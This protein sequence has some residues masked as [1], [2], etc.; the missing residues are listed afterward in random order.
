MG[1]TLWQPRG[2]FL[3]LGLYSLVHLVLRLLVP[4][5]LTIDD[6]REALFAQTFEWGYQARQPP[7]YNWLVWA[8]VRLFGV[9]IAS[10]SSVKYALLALA[11]AFLYLGARRILV[12]PRLAAP[13][14]FSLL[15]MVPVNWVVHEALTHSIAVLTAA[16]ATVYALIRLEASGRPWAYAGLGAALG[17]GLLSKFSYALFASALLLGAL[18]VQPF[19]RRLASPWLLLTAGVVALLLLP[20]GL[21][22]YG[23]DFSLTR[24]YAEEVDPG[25]P[26]PYLAGI[27][28]AL[29]YILRVTFYYVT[30]LWIVFLVLFPGAWRAPAPLSGRALA[31]RRLLERFFLAELGLLVAGA[32]FA[33]VTYLKFRWMMPAFFLVPLYVFSRLD[34]RAVETGRVRRFAQLLLVT[35]LVLVVAFLVNVYR[36]DR[37]GKPSHLTTPYDVVATRLAAAGFRTGTIAADEGPLAGNLRLWFPGSRIMRVE[38]PDYVPPPR[39]DGQCLIAWEG[40]EPGVPAK[41]REWIAATL[42]VA[43][44]GNEPVRL[45]EEPVHFARHRRLSVR[46]VLF[47]DGVGRCR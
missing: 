3:L 35:E 47:E 40:R 39:G 38:N 30:P 46:F 4:P 34:A 37:F 27:A 28:S 8:T 32:V 15:L 29:Y 17:L 2:F 5:V 20:Y 7:F 18:A 19:R 1:G 16:A 41:M 12:D 36:G 13:A 24:I 33:G 25:T 26:E 10:V 14:A 11:Y 23:H 44:T 9:G 6:A 45:I 43:L 21:W 22:F 42:G 31:G